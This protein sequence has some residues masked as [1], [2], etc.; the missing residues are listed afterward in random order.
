MEKIAIITGATGGV[1]QAFLHELQKESLDE[2]WV[3]GRNKKR[4]LALKDKYGEKIIP[5]CKDLTNRIDLL[6][7]SSLFEERSISIRWLV[8]NAGIASMAPSKEFSFSEIEQMIDLNCKAPISLI[9]FCI[10][11]MERG[12]N[13]LNISSASAFQPVPYINLYASTKVFER[14]YS[15]ALNLELKPYGITVTAVC[16][17]WVD[18]KMLK[19]SINGEKVRFHGIVTPEKVAKKAIIDAKKGKDMSICSFYV[20]CQHINVKLMPQKY[21]MKFWLHC[22]RKYI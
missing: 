21:T 18:T 20:K 22:I 11:Y 14:S 16:P 3:I 17:S 6:S 19:K 2:I 12:A 15:R 7:F 1:G 10:P 4:L 5:I 9:N 13:I 8:N